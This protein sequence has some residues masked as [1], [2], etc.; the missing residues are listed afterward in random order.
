MLGVGW[1]QTKGKSFVF[2]ADNHWY[3]TAFEDDLNQENFI[4]DFADSLIL[5]LKGD[6]LDF[7]FP[8]VLRDT[9][10]NSM[11]FEIGHEIELIFERE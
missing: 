11:I 1:N 5:T 7:R 10:P 2:K 6:N 8:L 9:T 4:Y 3:S